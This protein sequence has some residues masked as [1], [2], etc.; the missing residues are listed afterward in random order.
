MTIDSV[1][2]GLIAGVI[3]PFIVSWLQHQVI[4]RRQKRLETKYKIFEEAV[5]ALSL[6][7]TDA[8]DPKLQSEKSSYKGNSRLVEMRPGT[9]EFLEKSKGMVHAFFSKDTAAKYDHALRAHIAI[10]NIPN[11]DFEERRTDAIV[12]MATELGIRDG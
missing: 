8:M 3:S 4:W 7:S 2:A 10:D 11:E 6:W 9:V 1:V 12:A 5:R